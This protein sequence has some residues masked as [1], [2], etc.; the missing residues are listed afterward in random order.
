MLDD[1]ESLGE[2]DILSLES[3]GEQID[4]IEG[5]EEEEES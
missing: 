5:D 1:I 3:L 4:S 2:M